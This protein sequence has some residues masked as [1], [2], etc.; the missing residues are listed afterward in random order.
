MSM[1]TRMLS[2][3]GLALMTAI[4]VAVWS[5]GGAQAQEVEQTEPAVVETGTTMLTVRGI[6]TRALTPD[7]TTIQFEV[8]ALDETAQNAVRAGDRALRKIASRLRAYR[9]SDDQLH[10]QR[11]SLREE[12]DW[13]EQGRV[14]LGFRYSQSLTLQVEGTDRAGQLIDRIV[15]AGDGAVSINSVS[16]S[17]SG[18]AEAER[19]V[20]LAAMDD[21]RATADAMAAQI[22]KEIVDTIEVTV[23]SNLSPVATV[24][25]EEATSPEPAAAEIA[26]LIR[27]GQ[28]DVQVSV[29]MKFVAR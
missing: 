29:V 14:S 8:S 17:A 19:E 9:V 12:Y 3:A 4:A 23:A 11:V 6:A 5:F 1:R 27:A 7:R 18:R 22:G 20:L 24:E 15:S 21:A 10:T 26:L 28:D 2:A 25:S 16:F 13:T